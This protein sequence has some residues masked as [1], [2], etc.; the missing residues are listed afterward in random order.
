M[1]GESLEKYISLIESGALWSLI[2]ENNFWESDSTFL[3]IF[4]NAMETPLSG[5]GKSES[6][7][8]MYLEVPSL[9]D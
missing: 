9:K 5:N 8:I 2:E 3:R 7:R 4:E 6:D 1:E